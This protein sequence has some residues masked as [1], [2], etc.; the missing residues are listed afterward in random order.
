MPLAEVIPVLDP[1]EK[2]VFDGM[3]TQLRSEDPGLTQRLDRMCRPK[4]RIR[5]ALAFLLW[6]MAPLC[7]IFGGWTGLI[8]AVV[9]AGYGTVLYL[10]RGPGTGEAAWPSPRKPRVAD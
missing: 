7:I 8:L 6:T 2:A 4:R 9:G 10:K 5:T 1:N 3:V